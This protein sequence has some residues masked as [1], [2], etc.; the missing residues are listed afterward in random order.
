M[1]PN[2]RT[3]LHALALVPAALAAVLSG[4]SGGGTETPPPPPPGADN[5]G[6]ELPIMKN[7]PR[8]KA[9]AKTALRASNTTP[10]RWPSGSARLP[11]SL[12]G[13][14]E[15]EAPAEPPGFREC[16]APAEPFESAR[17]PPSPGLPGVRGSRRAAPAQPD[18]AGAS[19]SRKKR[20]SA[21]ASHP[22]GQ[23][24]AR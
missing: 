11:P 20:G 6:G 15:C 14:R 12:P 1:Q 2:R 21:G 7:V 3:L 17:L 24:Q 10:Q 16:E 22:R 5:A 9:G 8:G 13:F 18:S 23:T 19:N 4:C